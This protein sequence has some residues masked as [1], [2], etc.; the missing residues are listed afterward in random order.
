M[1]I[2]S[3]RVKVGYWAMDDYGPSSSYVDTSYTLYTIHFSGFGEYTKIYD[4]LL[5]NIANYRE[6]IDQLE[7]DLIKEQQDNEKIDE[8]YQDALSE[9]AALPWYKRWYKEVDRTQYRHKDEI[10][11]EQINLTSHLKLSE[12]RLQSLESFDPEYFNL[13]D[14]VRGNPERSQFYKYVVSK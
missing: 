8:D 2:K 3:R 11:K 1:E 7:N 9:I 4:G 5:K 10:K 6:K 12:N 14:E 13:I